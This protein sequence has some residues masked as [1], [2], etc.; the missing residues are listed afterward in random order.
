MKT[1]LTA[2]VALSFVT[3]C[4]STTTTTTNPGAGAHLSAAQQES[5]A[6]RDAREAAEHRHQ[7]DPKAASLKENC[8]P[9]GAGAR[10]GLGECWQSRVNP[11][12]VQL[13]EAKEHERQAAA[14]R[15][16]SQA[17]RTAEQRACA[18]LSEHDRD[19]SPFAHRSDILRVT[20][21]AKGAVVVF[22]PVPTM[23]AEGLQKIVDCHL[24][25]NDAL[26]HNVPWMLY[27]PLVP[28]DVTA[29]VT[30]NPDG[31]AV[32]IQTPDAEAAKEVKYRVG[33]LITPH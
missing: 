20:Q 10:A 5:A 8:T 3:A 2:V 18:G 4:A 24:A 1:T 14:H 32:D 33:A 25:R 23:T 31:L 29:K 16:A 6:D 28:R 21:T 15:A 19:V 26:A 9:G 17:L 11:T 13:E 27:C 7:F 30:Q 22:R 12:D